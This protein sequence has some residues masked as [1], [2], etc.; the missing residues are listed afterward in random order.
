MRKKIRVTDVL[1]SYVIRYH[2]KLIWPTTV[3][4]YEKLSRRGTNCNLWRESRKQGL[5]E[6]PKYI[7]LTKTLLLLNGKGLAT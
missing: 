5:Q 2:T 7:V 1:G 4:D 6:I 3:S